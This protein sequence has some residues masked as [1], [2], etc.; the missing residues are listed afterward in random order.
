MSTT[1]IKRHD[2][3]R[4]LSKEHHYGLVLC[5]KIRTGISKGI[6]I[7]R[8][9]KYVDWFYKTH[10]AAHFSIEEKHLFTILG[11]DHLLV[12]KALSQHRR[13]EKLFRQTDALE[14]AIHSIEEKL[15]QHIRF[16]ERILFS[17]IQ[18][19]ASPEQLKAFLEAHDDTPFVENTTD[20]FWKD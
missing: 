11:P 2:A 10:L 20:E 18:Q 7:E 5:W 16:E 14:K 6:E 15:E 17:E 3:L 13:L 8:I 9:K 1:P 4:S 12:K 19:K